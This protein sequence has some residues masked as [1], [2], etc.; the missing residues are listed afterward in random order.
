MA[1]SIGAR[2]RYQLDRKGEAFQRIYKQRTATERI[3]SQAV[4]LG[5]EYPKLR[6]QR[7]IAN[8]NTLIY[9]VLNLRALDR[10]LLHK[11]QQLAVSA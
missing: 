5:I 2:I 8:Q 1:T 10:V 6:N 11:Q 4:E 3:N 7:S 9:I